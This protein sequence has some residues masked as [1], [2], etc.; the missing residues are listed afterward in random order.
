MM[1]V[2]DPIIFGYAVKSFYSDIFKKYANTLD[3]LGVNERNGIG[4]LYTKINDLPENKKKAI[5]SDIESLYKERPPLAMVDSDKGITNL[6]VPSNVIFDASM[7][8]AIKSSGKM[9]GPDG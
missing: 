8:A 9:W 5:V 6:H 3:E 2:S 1:K 7:P 4:D